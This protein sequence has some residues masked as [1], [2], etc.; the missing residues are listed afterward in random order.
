M[1]GDCARVAFEKKAKKKGRRRSTNNNF[2]ITTDSSPQIGRAAILVWR[3]C[4]KNA[5]KSA[6]ERS[7][8]WLINL[9]I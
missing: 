2:F 4:A 8:D 3:I 6:Q 9:S 1:A 5:N 7:L